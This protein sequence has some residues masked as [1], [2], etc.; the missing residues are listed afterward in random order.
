VK[1]RGI[2][3][4]PLNGGFSIQDAGSATYVR[5]DGV[6]LSD[7]PRMGDYWEIEGTTVAYFPH[8][9]GDEGCSTRNRS[10]AGAASSGVGPN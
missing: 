9:P 3:T 8:R 1:I 4:A 5:M 10:S 7:V 6:T 2:I